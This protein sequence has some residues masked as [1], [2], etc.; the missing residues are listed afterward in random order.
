MVQRGR[1]I[2]GR[3][4]FGYVYRETREDGRGT[5]PIVPYEPEAAVVRRIFAEYVRG[6]PQ[7]QIARDL[8]ADGVKT[9][10]G[11]AWYATTVAGMLRNPLYVG[12]V[13]IDGESFPGEHEPIIDAETWALTCQLREATAESVGR[14]RGRRTAGWHLLTGGLARCTCGGA[15]SPVTKNKTHPGDL[16]EVYTCVQR[17]HH[18]PAACSQPPI[19]GSPGMIGGDDTRTRVFFLAL[20]TASPVFRHDARS[21]PG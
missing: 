21:T 15:M 4:P 7:N 10:T 16:Y 8:V 11:T 1:Y 14:G 2:G 5:G 19:K 17:L 12:R 9:L 18:G 20:R 6:I 13:V 3:R